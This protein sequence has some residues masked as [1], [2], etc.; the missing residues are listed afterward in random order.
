MKPSLTQTLRWAFRI[1]PGS[2]RRGSS[3]ITVLSFSVITL[4]VGAS[5]LA[6]GSSESRNAHQRLNSAQAFWL[7]EAGFQRFMAEEYNSTA[8]ATSHRAFSDT[9]AGGTYTLSI[10]DTTVAGLG[11]GVTPYHV[12]SNGVSTSYR[13]TSGRTLDLLVTVQPATAGINLGTAMPS[14]YTALAIGNTAVSIGGS[15]V[16]SGTA[17]NIGVPA[18]GSISVG[19]PSNLTGIEYV[20]T[21][22]S[23]SGSGAGGVVQN[24][25]I[26]AQ[27][28][29][30][31]TDALAAS[32]SY[33]ALTATIGTT[34]ITGS[35]TVTGSSGQNVMNLTSFS[36]GNGTTVTINAP[37]GST[38]VINVSTTFDVK[39]ATISLAG[40]ITA[41]DVLW[42][43][44]GSGGTL[45]MNGT[46]AFSGILLIPNS[47]AKLNGGC[48]MTGMI[49]C[50]GSSL[51]LTGNCTITG[52]GASTATGGGPALASVHRAEK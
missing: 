3:L 46:A 40:G 6:A 31:K 26:D 2:S 13:G 17:A 38:F 43:F 41:A 36:P 39:H 14:M 9:L 10:R 28:A 35:A 45:K 5:I 33:G 49:I 29:Q 1:S 19:S 20:S 4:S 18:G 48:T 21:S 32:T 27:L 25:T 50:G 52:C 23:F 30:A 12:F 24:S 15:S 34:S 7:A 42:N 16:V 22:A 11:A 51:D 8:W 47:S 37:A 44:T